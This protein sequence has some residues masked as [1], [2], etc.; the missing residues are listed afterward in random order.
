MT[1]MANILRFAALSLVLLA[2]A[3]APSRPPTSWTPSGALDTRS[4]TMTLDSNG[5]SL[6]IMAVLPRDRS[7]ALPV[8]VFMADEGVPPDQ[9]DRLMNDWAAQGY[10]VLA[11]L[12]G[13]GL[14]ARLTQARLLLTGLSDIE[15][16]T[17]VALDRTRIAAAGHGL[18]ALVAQILGGAR[19]VGL[20]GIN[21]R[22]SK[23][24]AVLAL[25]PPSPRADLVAAADWASV[26]VPMLI[27]VG[28]QDPQ[29]RERA[30]AYRASRTGGKLLIVNSGIGHDFDQAYRSDGQ[31]TPAGAAAYSAMMATS[32]AFLDAHVRGDL[33]AYAWL[34]ERQPF[35]LWPQ[36]FTSFERR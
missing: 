10:A 22:E 5:Q 11:P 6:A 29:A 15:A 12:G 4:Q 26:A 32:I 36:A 9:Y 14:A 3:C 17:G 30:T 18:G 21:G 24:L 20:E 7:A 1:V 31:S 16:G 2:A 27:Q 25:S 33:S 34:N 28:A 8:L 35:K 19:P 23:V 13:T